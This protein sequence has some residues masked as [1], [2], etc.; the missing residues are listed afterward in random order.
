MN[1]DGDDKAR[2]IV[3]RHR[4]MNLQKCSSESNARQRQDCH[5]NSEVNWDDVLERINA[6]E[7]NLADAR[8]MISAS[9]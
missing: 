2:D 1:S 3:N 7:L 6:L 5:W 9:T 8:P 4:T